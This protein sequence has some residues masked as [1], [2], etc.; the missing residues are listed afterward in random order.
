MGPPVPQDP[1]KV[2]KRQL[3]GRVGTGVFAFGI[4][5]SGWMAMRNDD[6][7]QM[8]LWAVV[9]TGCGWFASRFATWSR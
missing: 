8:L 1:K 6:W 2:G 3:I 7:R 9:A 4:F 5:M